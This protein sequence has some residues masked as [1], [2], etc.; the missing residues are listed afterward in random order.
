MHSPTVDRIGLNKK[1]TQRFPLAG[2]NHAFNGYH[3][4]HSDFNT[5]NGFLTGPEGLIGGS[6]VIPADRTDSR[7]RRRQVRPDY[8]LFPVSCSFFHKKRQR[9]G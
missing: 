5:Q 3:S 2:L 4:H 8:G 7:D 1:I 9:L 6:L